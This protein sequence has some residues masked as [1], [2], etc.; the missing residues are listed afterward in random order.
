[1]RRGEARSPAAG[2]GGAG[3]PRPVGARA[4]PGFWPTIP[5][6]KTKTALPPA[7]AF[8]LLAGCA[9]L[10]AERGFG[11]VREQM[12]ARGVTLSAKVAASDAA[13]PLP[14]SLGYEEALQLALADNPR[15]AALYA[16]LGLASADVYDAGRLSNPRFSG[17]VMTP[18]T[19]GDV[20]QLT[21]GIA[22]RFTDLLLLPARR[23]FAAREFERV[24]FEVGQAV[25]DLLL[26]V[27]RA[28][29]TLL[30]A[31]QGL[32][33]R[34]Q[35]LRA[36]NASALLAQRTAEAGSLPPRALAAAQAAAQEASLEA[37]AAQSR[38]DSA[39]ARMAELLGRTPA[40][41]WTAAGKLAPDPDAKP[42][43]GRIRQQAAA[44][45]LDL[46]A[47]HRQ[48]DALEDELGV[49][50]H[51]RWLGEIEI[52]VET[53]R[54]TDRSRITGPRFALELP[55]FN[56]GDGKLLRAQARLEQARSEVTALELQVA[57]EVASALSRVQALQASI[58]IQSGQL[59]PT[60]EALVGHLQA[61]LNYMLEGPFE[62]LQAR[63]AQIEAWERYVDT[64][65]DYWIARAELAHAAGYHETLVAGASRTT[66]DQP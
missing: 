21:F 46:Q 57:R 59:L 47:A 49:A 8:C 50:R 7:L 22:Q 54:E 44:T 14:R 60:R 28:W 33:L 4:R 48:L 65:R 53:E 12:A 31:Q 61:E 63:Q 43:E 56:H 29:Y 30:G 39:R 16:R 1:M 38:L 25:L 42:D 45:R 52:G 36:A 40:G 51:T 6:V 17:A 55:I 64:L 32:E 34:Q 15:T 18:D 27:D 24:Q 37:L 35:I 5:Q 41:D 20:N 3:H 26:E 19:A 11:G 13:T 23:R 62:V 2:R 10:P 58:A 9:S 66:G